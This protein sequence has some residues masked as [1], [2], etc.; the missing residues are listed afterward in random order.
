MPWRIIIPAVCILAG[1]G[2]W[3]LEKNQA[4]KS[5]GHE[6]IHIVHFG[7]SIT[8]APRNGQTID[9]LTQAKLREIYGNEN[10]VCHN[11]SRGGR[12]IKKLMSAGETYDTK[13]AG[14]IKHIDVA[15]IQFGIN[16]EDAYGA[17][18]FKTRQAAMCDRIEKEY[19]GVT[20]VLCTSMKV[21]TRDWWAENGPD[22]EEPI[23][24]KFY[25]QTRALAAQR[26]YV[27]VDV[28]QK[29][30]DEMNAGNWD[31]YIRNQKLSMQH[32]G[33]VIT[34][35]SKDADRLED[36]A[37]WFRDVHPNI[38]GLTLIADLE[39]QVLKKTY[40]DGLP[41]AAEQNPK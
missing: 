27:L 22:A 9:T 2:L 16:D 3:A 28:Y 25:S 11:V 12:T 31:M 1:G 20:I 36:G 10:I 13:C 14:V 21:K 32:Y 37:Q 29:L 17:E 38:R 8:N 26:G 41:I 15:L 23:S 34:D 33:K 35:D 30:V 4:N 6:M 40:P 18:E 39:V 5:K 7:D 24:K 19:P